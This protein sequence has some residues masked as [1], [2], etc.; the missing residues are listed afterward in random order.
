MPVERWA[1]CPRRPTPLVCT[2]KGKKDYFECSVRFGRLKLNRS[3]LVIALVMMLVRSPAITESANSTRSQVKND[4]SLCRR[5]KV[6]WVATFSRNGRS[7]WGP[8]SGSTSLERGPGSGRAASAEVGGG[9]RSIPV[10]IQ[11][12]SRSRDYK[13]FRSSRWASF[14]HCRFG[15]RVENESQFAG[16]LGHEIGHVIAR[17]DDLRSIQNDRRRCRP[18]RWA[19]T[20]CP[21]L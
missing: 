7:V 1:P 6:Q 14:H 4:A 13:R 2:S 9:L 17:P 21:I 18:E 11:S 8:S 3:G 5:R 19:S 15:E 12:A 20:C 10:F 16:V